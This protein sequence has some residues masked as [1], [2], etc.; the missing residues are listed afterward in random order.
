M[1]CSS[2]ALQHTILENISSIAPILT[3]IASFSLAFYVFIYQRSKDNKEKAERIKELHRNVRLQW[4]KDAIIQ[5]NLDGIYAFFKM[6]HK[7]SL[8]LRKK[9]M[10][11][12]Q[13]I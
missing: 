9:N 11:I 2:V 1:C 5:P 3:A 8:E 10:T 4:F 12:E 13:K 6:M 7:E